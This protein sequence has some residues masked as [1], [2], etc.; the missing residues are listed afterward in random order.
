MASNNQ[1]NAI[2]AARGYPQFSGTSLIPP[3]YSQRMIDRCYSKA[4]ASDISVTDFYDDIKKCG[5]EIIFRFK[6]IMR[7]HRLAK[8]GKFQHSTPEVTTVRLG[9][10]D[11]RGASLKIDE[12]D[13]LTMCAWDAYLSGASESVAN[14]IAMHMDREILCRIPAEA[15]KCNVGDAAGVISG[16]YQLGIPG[17]PVVL[18]STNVWEYM[19]Y[20]QAVLMER[21]D[22]C[23]QGNPY[24]VFP[25][26]M[27]PVLLNSPKITENAALAQ[28]CGDAACG[29]V[30]NGL[31]PMTIAG[32]DVYF[33]NN[34]C[35]TFEPL[36][37]TV[38]YQIP[39][40]YR[41]ATAFYAMSEGM[42][43]KIQMDV[44]TKDDY[45]QTTT[46]FGMGV[47]RKDLVGVL[48][49]RIS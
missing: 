39:F 23:G 1:I 4:I 27:Y 11:R 13:R 18:D 15:D 26:T 24:A 17:A 46:V 22:A 5:D 48:Y 6:P 32:F 41:E 7:S 20:M 10:N 36:L 16:S 38:A 28:A 44:D 37:N 30:L 45:F 8:D 31:V 47:M 3:V 40:G 43:A 42:V 19:T 21:G 2:P 12:R 49:A 9:I 33:S 35:T 34:V 25:T 29:A 14:D